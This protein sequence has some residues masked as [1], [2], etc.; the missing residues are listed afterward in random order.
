M[1]GA[2]N[3]I[4][5][6]MAH[7]REDRTRMLLR[8]LRADGFDLNAA[9]RRI[10]AHAEWWLDNTDMRMDN[11]LPPVDQDELTPDVGAQRCTCCGIAPCAHADLL[12]PSGFDVY[13]HPVLIARPANHVRPAGSKPIASTY[14]ANAVRAT[15][16]TVARCCDLIARLNLPGDGMLVLYDCRGVTT[17]NWDLEYATQIV[18]HLGDNFPE[19]IFVVLVV[20]NSWM[21]SGLWAMVSALLPKEVVAKVVFCGDDLRKASV[22]LGDDHPYL[23]AAGRAPSMR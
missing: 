16:H 4:R 23:A 6:C 14:T 19:R 10:R 15:V 2:T 3:S 12:Y 7:E 22:H 20:Y 17:A 5:H 13:G 18:A 8:F 21:L 1:Q 9:E 11:A